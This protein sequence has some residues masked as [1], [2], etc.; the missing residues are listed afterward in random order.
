MR[1]P[2]R[3]T[4]GERILAA[5][6]HLLTI[7]SLPGMLLASLI[8]L[9]HR[10]RSRYVAMQARQAVLWQTAGHIIVFLLLIL[11]LLTWILALGGSESSGVSGQVAG[12]SM[13]GS[14]I[15]LFLIPMGATVFFFSSSL[16]G[17]IASLMGKKYTYPVIGRLAHRSVEPS[18][19]LRGLPKPAKPARTK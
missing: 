7:F 9:T 16:V 11:L 17:A 3:P 14:T 1:H 10:R 8:W 13:I 19:D 15:L 4:G 6:A 2:S 5:G 12:S 18:A